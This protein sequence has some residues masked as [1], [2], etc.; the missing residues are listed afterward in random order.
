MWIYGASGHGKVI[1]DCL[2]AN[3]KEIKG[4]IDDNL[5]IKNFLGYPIISFSQFD[6]NKE[7]IIIGIGDN[8]T[9]KTISRKQNLRFESVVHPSAIFSSYSTLGIGSVIFQQAVVQSGCLIGN[10]CIVNT[11]ASVDHDCIIGDYAHIAPGATVCG[12]VKIGSL[13]W[14]GA[15]STIIQ[16]VEIG[17]NALIGMGSIVI[18]NVP[19]NAVVVGNPAKIIRYQDEHEIHKKSNVYIVG[20]GG[21]GREIESWISLS[22]S[23]RDNY[24]LKGYIDDGTDALDQYPSDYNILGKIDEFQFKDEDYV[25]LGV[26]DP[27]MKENIVNRLNDK[28]R[29]LSFISDSAIIGKNIEISNGTVIAPHAVISTNINIGSFVTINLGTHIGHDSVVS[30]FSSLM[31]NVDLSGQTKIGKNVFI[32]SNATIFPGREIGDNSKISAGS[33][34]VNNVKSNSLMGGNPAREFP[35]IFKKSN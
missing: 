35:K 32:G 24:S 9:R 4:F 18:K 15:G 29:F 30:D 31:A 2:R 14:I 25:L 23:F 22:K 16:E 34:V 21:F 10:H 5:S 6:S 13:A 20:A 27:D 33:I 12:S 1:L 11:N 28:V 19:D 7:L 26:A 8:H 3:G 17:R